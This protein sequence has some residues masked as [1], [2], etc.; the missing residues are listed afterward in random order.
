MVQGREQAPWLTELAMGGVMLFW[1]LNYVVL[2]FGLRQVSPETF[3]LVRFL[4]AGPVIL[5]L[6]RVLSGRLYLPRR[7]IFG[8]I[9]VGLLGISVYQTLF[10][11]A[12]Q[13]TTAAAASLLIAIS[14]I[15]TALLAPLFGEARSGLRNWLGMA[16]SVI[17]TAGLLLVSGGLASA[18]APHPLLGDV[19]SLGASISWALYSILARPLLVRHPPVLVVGWT[20]LAGAVGLLPFGV[21]GLTALSRA[22]LASWMS[23][24]FAVFLVTAYGLVVWQIGIQRMGTVRTMV[25][26]YMVPVIASIAGVIWIGEPVRPLEAVCGGV[27]LLGMIVARSPSR[28]RKAREQISQI[29]A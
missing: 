5:G 19:L 23:L 1:G 18:T 6:H 14:P 25:Y 8:L 15:F 21:A 4:L 29:E 22:D 28:D 13:D 12:V 27:V 26:L 17:G 9:G 24:M 11:A 3:T 7:D 2:K 20:S 16:I 10:S